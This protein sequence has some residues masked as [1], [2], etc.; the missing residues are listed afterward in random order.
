MHV[1]V[2]VHLAQVPVEV[3]LQS[4]LQTGIGLPDP[5]LGLVQGRR[6]IVRPTGACTAPPEFIRAGVSI[7]IL[8]RMCG[9]GAGS[10]AGASAGA[11][12]YPGAGVTSVAISTG[13]A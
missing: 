8:Q 2:H 9:A 13:V 10:F 1:Q 4:L 7:H 3:V 6:R 5:L 12:S 11:G